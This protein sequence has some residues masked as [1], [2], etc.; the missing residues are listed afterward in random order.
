V[1]GTGTDI[2]ER[3]AA[4][5]KLREAEQKYRTVADFTYDWEYWEALD[6]SLVYVSPSCE[7]ISGYCPTEFLERPELISE[8][9]LPEDLSL[10]NA[11]SH[12]SDAEPAK[13]DCQFRIRTKDGTT[14]WI[15]HVC[16]PVYDEQGNYSGVRASN[17]DITSLRL[18]EQEVRKNQEILARLNRTVNLEQLAGSIAHELNQ[19]LTGILSN[20]QA[21]EMLLK[22]GDGNR[23]EIE[24]ILTDI[25]ADGKRAGDILR[26]LREL[27]GRQTAEFMLL[28]VNKMVE[29]TI[30][31]LNSEFVIQSLN[32]RL[33]LSDTLPDVM[34]NKIQLQ[35]VLIN[36]VNN[37]IHAMQNVE[38]ADR[39]ISIVTE[40]GNEGQVQVHV[41]DTG[42]GIDPEQLE[43]IFESL[44][45]SKR[46]GLGMGLSIS[47]SIIQAHSGRIWA[48]N[49]TAGGARISFTLPAAEGQS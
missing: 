21:G 6:N 1:W 15:E 17:R 35:Q 45:T 11:H 39:S 13:S 24:E 5:D 31:L 47:R 49:I 3:K 18:A 38:E 34:G 37:A 30:R 7:H 32:I 27:F 43:S 12:G 29:E 8:I 42:S 48:E 33:I 9:I 46:G 10:W 25:I 40:R 20:A 16:R 22:R 26:N 14:R 28:G 44:A 4:E 23:T 41:E 2:T 36:L 19:P